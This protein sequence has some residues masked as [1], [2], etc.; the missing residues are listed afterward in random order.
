[1]DANTVNWMSYVDHRHVIR[2]DPISLFRGWIRCSGTSCPY[3]PD[4]VLHQFGSVQRLPLD[5][6]FIPPSSDQ[7]DSMWLNFQ[8]HIFQPSLAAVHPT[9]TVDN[10]EE[11]YREHSHPLMKPPEITSESV[12]IVHT[13][14]LCLDNG[15]D[16]FFFN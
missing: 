3:L 15:L 13:C 5:P 4:S 10:Y 6:L 8:V 7:I 11:W 1:M 14:F 12:S 16:A 9:Q 2:F